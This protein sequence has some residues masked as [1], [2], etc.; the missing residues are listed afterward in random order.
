MDNKD[1][2]SELY[3]KLNWPLINEDIDNSRWNDKCD[4]IEIEKCVNLNPDKYNFILVQ[5]TFGVF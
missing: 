4:Y 5:L 2:E 3:D 1:S